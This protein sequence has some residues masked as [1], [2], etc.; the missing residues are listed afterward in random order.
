MPSSRTIAKYPKVWK[1]G[2]LT[3]EDV[4]R[5]LRYVGN[6]QREEANST[7]R[8]V[9]VGEPYSE[10]EPRD[11]EVAGMDPFYYALRQM[12]KR[13]REAARQNK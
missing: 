12:E 7:Q 2:E 9:L 10:P 4:R 11:S 8:F 6:V 1:R 13:E 3:P 5:L